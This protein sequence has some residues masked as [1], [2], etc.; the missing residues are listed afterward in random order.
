MEN[1]CNIFFAIEPTFAYLIH[2]CFSSSAFILQLGGE[3]YE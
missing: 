2:P 3:V 1:K